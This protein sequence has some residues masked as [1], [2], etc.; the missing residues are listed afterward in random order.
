MVL[1][2]AVL[3]AGAFI[4]P[5]RE[6]VEA[7]LGWASGRG[8]WAGV[9]LAAVWVPAALFLVPGSLLTLGTGFLLG[10]W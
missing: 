3:A 5:V 9:L 6:A 4:L 7:F 2:A 1:A 10:A 8:V